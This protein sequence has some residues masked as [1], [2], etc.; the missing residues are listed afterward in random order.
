MGKTFNLGW[1]P[2]VEA[3]CRSLFW[4]KLQISTQFSHPWGKIWTYNLRRAYGLWNHR[5]KT[6]LLHHHMSPCSELPVSV[7][8]ESYWSLREWNPRTSVG[9]LS[10]QFNDLL[11]WP[12][13][14]LTPMLC[15]NWCQGWLNESSRGLF[16]EILNDQY[17]S[18]KR[19]PMP[20][21]FLRL[22]RIWLAESLL[23][24]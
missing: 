4:V 9:L 22:L 12:L 20:L 18:K 3:G 24:V 8:A 7:K 6:K 16:Y 13:A 11:I 15:A 10:P 19:D 5:L 1:T 23:F 14:I 21:N 2:I 17:G